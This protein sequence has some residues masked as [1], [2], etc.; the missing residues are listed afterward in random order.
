MAGM[1]ARAIARMGSANAARI[2]FMSAPGNWI[3][4]WR[5]SW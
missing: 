5:E 4:P 2:V 3:P 1:L